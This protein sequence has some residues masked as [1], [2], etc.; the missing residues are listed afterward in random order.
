[1]TPAEFEWR[2]EQL[3]IAYEKGR[4]SSTDFWRGMKA[5]GFSRETCDQILEEMNA[6]RATLV[7]NGDNA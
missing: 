1:M 6:R 3:E 2:Q 4:T 7:A 5:L